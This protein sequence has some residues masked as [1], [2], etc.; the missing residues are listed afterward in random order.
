MIQLAFI[1]TYI[2]KNVIPTK[3]FGQTLH[4]CS[5]ELRLYV[6]IGQRQDDPL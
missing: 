2:D 1:R 3:S 5:Q 4:G 6:K